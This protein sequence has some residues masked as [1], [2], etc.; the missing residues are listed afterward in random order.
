MNCTDHT[1]TIDLFQNYYQVFPKHTYNYPSQMIDDLNEVSHYTNDPYAW[2]TGQFIKHV[3]ILNRKTRSLI[4]S[5]VEQKQ[6]QKPYF[7]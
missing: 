6:I 1:I 5:A 2:L 7:G 3:L 4:E